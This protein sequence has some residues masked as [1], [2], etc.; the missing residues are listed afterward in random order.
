VNNKLALSLATL[1]YDH[2][3]DLILGNVTAEGIA[4]NYLELSY[5]EILLRGVLFHD[6]DVAE[7]SF[8]KYAALRASG[9]DSL[10]AIPVFPNRMVRHNSIYVLAGGPI[11]TPADLAGRRIGLPEW[12]Q[13][14]AVYVRGLLAH[15]YG[16]D[17]RSIDWL[18]AGADEPG[19][20]E[21]VALNLPAG[22]RLT[23]VP[24][25]S[26]SDMLPAGDVD[27][28]I[29]A[30]PPR[31][32]QPG[33]NVRRLFEDSL[34][35][36]M[37]YVEETGIYP[38]MHTIVIRK[39]ILDRA[40]WVAANLYAAFEEAKRLS[41]E[42][43]L[44]S[45][46]SMFPIAWHA[47]HARRAQQLIGPDLFPYGVEPNRVTLEAF[48]DYAYEQGVCARRLAI[49]ELFAPSTLVHAHV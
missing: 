19:R 25:R 22:L 3:T 8:A 46:A 32:Y 26:L 35:A 24:A 2:V 34:S 44:Y 6:F 12:A 9:D 31:C 20:T 49:E 47:E 38:I 7:I 33:T 10:V 1:R 16:I 37:R 29:C 17:L 43:A 13:T 23:P 14:A 41:V 28:I 45:G 48:L 42:R 4:L 27:A 39:D 18:Q 36:E 21:K 11:A 15:Y 40:P 5:H 30:Q